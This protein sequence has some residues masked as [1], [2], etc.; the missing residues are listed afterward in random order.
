MGEALFCATSLEF[1]LDSVRKTIGSNYEINFISTT[2]LTKTA[3]NDGAIEKPQKYT[4]LE[5]AKEIEAPKKLNCHPMTYPY[6]VFGCHSVKN[7]KV[8]RLLLE[9][10]DKSKVDAVAV[11]HMD[12]SDWKVDALFLLAAG[13]KPG[14]GAVCHFMQPSHFSVYA[15]TKE[16]REA[17]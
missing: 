10:E 7:T 3:S 12:T 5:A 14:E 13:L 2:H 6:P 4:L 1:L 15:S 17:I 8:Y 16:A 9:G 11:C